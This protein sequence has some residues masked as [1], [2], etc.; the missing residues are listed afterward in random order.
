LGSGSRFKDSEEEEK[1]K[2]RSMREEEEKLAEIRKKV[3][4]RRQQ[5]L[6]FPLLFPIA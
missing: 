3:A 4:T 5:N 1:G 6:G 2:S